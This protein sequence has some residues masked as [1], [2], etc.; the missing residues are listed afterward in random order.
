MVPF[1]PRVRTCWNPE[2]LAQVGQADTSLHHNWQGN[3][4]LPVPLRQVSYSGGSGSWLASPVITLMGQKGVQHLMA[5]G[6]ALPC[7]ATCRQLEEG[8]QQTLGFPCLGIF[9]GP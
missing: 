8:R 1:V 2:R 5:Q 7:S 9:L 3:S 4:V 6:P